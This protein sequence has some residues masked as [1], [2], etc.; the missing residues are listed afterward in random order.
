[1]A[2]SVYG[3]NI[4]FGR[5][6]VHFLLLPFLRFFSSPLCRPF[7]QLQV[8]DEHYKLAIYVTPS[9]CDDEVCNSARIRLPAAEK[10]PCRQPVDMPAGF[11][12]PG[13]PKNQT[14]NFTIF[15]LED[16]L[17]KVCTYLDICLSRASFAASLLF[18]FHIL[19]AGNSF[20]PPPRRSPLFVTRV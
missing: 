5:S 1:M 18:I 19:C 7:C 17:M 10:M 8:Y 6:P 12:D 4:T 13:V 3:G 2:S 14:L 11:L 15:A 9:R 16:V 20:L